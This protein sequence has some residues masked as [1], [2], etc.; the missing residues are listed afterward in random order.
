MYILLAA[1]FSVLVGLFAPGMSDAYIWR[2]HTPRGDV[3]TEQPHGYNDCQEFDGTYN[4]S[5]APPPAYNAPSQPAPQT[6]PPTVVA[7]PAPPYAY[8]PYPYPYPYAYAPYYYPA[9]GLYIGPP[10]FSFRF[11]FGGHGHFRR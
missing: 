4:P 1:S 7:P 5:A 11:G 8:A 2:C 9:P 10:L 6:A 3:W